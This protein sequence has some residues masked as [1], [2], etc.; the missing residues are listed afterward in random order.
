MSERERLTVYVTKYWQTAGI[1]ERDVEVNQK[2]TMVSWR[3][4]SGCV[5]HAHGEGREW[6][7]TEEA[8][9]WHVRGKVLRKLESLRKQIDKYEKLAWEYESATTPE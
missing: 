7:R 2:G 5:S 4:P 3:D 9:R 1:L 6:H 8:A